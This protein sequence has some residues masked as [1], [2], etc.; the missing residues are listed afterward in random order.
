MSANPDMAAGKRARI[1]AMKA[2]KAENDASRGFS[3]GSGFDGLR[4]PLE[5]HQRAV[6]GTGDA[7]QVVCHTSRVLATGDFLL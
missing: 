6:T 2:K 7:R 4:R 3:L 5:E 1:K